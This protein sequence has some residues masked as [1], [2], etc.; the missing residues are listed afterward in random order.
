[1]K[2]KNKGDS[3]TNCA[4]TL[5]VPPTAFRVAKR[6]AKNHKNSGFS[7]LELLIAVIILGILVAPLLHAFLSSANAAQKSRSVGSATN[8]ASNLVEQIKAMRSITD[9]TGDVEAD[10]NGVYVVK[11]ENYVYRS[12]TYNGTVTLDPRPYKT[13]PAA[14]SPSGINDREF[15]KYSTDG[16]KYGM[17]NDSAIDLAALGYYAMPIA[18][19]LAADATAAAAAEAGAPVPPFPV[20]A[21]INEAMLLV[22]PG[23]SR[24]I[25]LYI[26]ESGDNLTLRSSFRY[27]YNGEE[28]I[29]ET[30]TFTV[31]KNPALF[32]FYYPFYGTAADTITVYNNPD[33]GAN[34]NV[35]NLQIFLVKQRSSDALIALNGGNLQFAD[36]NYIN[37]YSANAFTLKQYPGKNAAI[38]SSNVAVNV[39]TLETSALGASFRYNL[40]SRLYGDNWIR[41]SEKLENTLV[42]HYKDT[43]RMYRVS[44]LLTDELDGSE[45]SLDASKLSFPVEDGG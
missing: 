23:L 28:F 13:D 22:M 30:A 36:S 31:A 43:N 26:E 34:V 32:F 1:M 9:F 2:R 18:E 25:S 37:K 5:A 17:D 19:Q 24:H 41:V 21:F 33:G 16:I 27:E 35:E 14:G 44:V 6:S 29:D 12:R 45:I 7:L 15:V 8:A 10:A 3:L 40:H 4:V 39:A 38:L 11:I 20:E 42:E